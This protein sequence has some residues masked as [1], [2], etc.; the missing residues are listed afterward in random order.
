MA[1]QCTSRPVQNVDAEKEAVG[2]EM[3]ELVDILGQKR[4][5]VIDSGAVVSVMS[6]GAWERLKRKCP[7]WEEKVEVLAKPNFSLVDASKAK[8]P[9]REQIKVEI[10]IRGRKAVVVFQLVENEL[11][12]FLLGTNS[13]ET[14]GVELKWKA[15][16]AVA[17]AARKLTRE[18]FI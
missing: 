16:R 18:P 7:E 6:T 4:R 15:E 9:V 14:V 5:I 17:R 12:I 8:M 13:F 10:G 2:A 1:R 11:D 3:V